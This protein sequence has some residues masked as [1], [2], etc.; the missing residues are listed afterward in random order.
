[1]VTLLFSGLPE[2][3]SISA[4]TW[5]LLVIAAIAIGISKSALPGAATLAV[6]LFATALPAKESTGTMLIL[7]L[8]GDVM[9]ISMYHRE[10]D[11]AALKRLVPGVLAGVVLGATFLHFASDQFTKRFI[12]ALL[13]VLI[14]ATMALMRLPKPPEIQGRLGRAVYGTLA[15]FT[16]MAANAGGPVTTMYFL[17]SRF[18][19]MSFLGTTAWFFGIVNVL[20]LPFSIGLGII[21]PSTLWIDAVLAPVVVVSAFVGRWLAKRMHKQLFDAVVTVL[22]VASAAYLLIA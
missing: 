2:L 8:V 18:S 3:T 6:A 13:L 10:A 19:V 9:A 15:G 12:G 4:P 21:K 22:T 1:M 16:T 17:A 7:L 11:W 20:K 14:A 5:G